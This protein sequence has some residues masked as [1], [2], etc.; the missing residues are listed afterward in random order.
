MSLRCSRPAGSPWS[1]R[2]AAPAC[3]AE[4]VTR[5]AVV[6]AVAGRRL[7]HAAASSATAAQLASLRV[8][9]VGGARLADK[10]ARRIEPVLGGRLQQVFGMAEGLLNYTRLDDPAKAVTTTQGR[11]L[12]PADEVRLV[13]EFDKDVL[14]GEPGSLLARGPYTPPELPVGRRRP[15]L[16]SAAAQWTGAKRRPGLRRPARRTPDAVTS[17]RRP[18][19]HAGRKRSAPARVARDAN[20]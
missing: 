20:V 8:L 4:G 12:S 16:G 11:P 1:A 18:A 7:G 2:P 19:E 14:P 3:E 9:Q 10:L 6:S 13:D 5:T 17:R 15:G